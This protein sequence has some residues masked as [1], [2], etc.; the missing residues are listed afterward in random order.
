MTREFFNRIVMPT[1]FSECSEEA[2]KVAQR[3]AAAG[4]SEILLAHVFVE[5]PSYGE[6]ALPPVYA[7]QLIEEAKKWVANELEKWADGPR[8][9]GITVRTVVLTG[10]P[11]QKIVELVKDERADLVAMGTHGRGGVSRLLLGSVADRVIRFAPCPVLTV[12]APE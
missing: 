1:D 7:W 2:W 8:A 12:R 11:H 3:L 9:K 4:G 10:S 6:P 5:P